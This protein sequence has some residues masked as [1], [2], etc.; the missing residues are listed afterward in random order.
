MHHILQRCHQACKRWWAAWAA[1]KCSREIRYATSLQLHAQL[2]RSGPIAGSLERVDPR[3]GRRGQPGV[4]AQPE[5]TPHLSGRLRRKRR[6]QRHGPS[7]AR[8]RP[9]CRPVPVATR[10]GPGRRQRHRQRT[11]DVAARPSYTLPFGAFVT[12]GGV[13]YGSA[14]SPCSVFPVARGLPSY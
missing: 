2:E 8:R 9:R 10:R 11:R 4:L 12:F 5:H 13:C 14:H 3:V 1:K 6:V 7:R